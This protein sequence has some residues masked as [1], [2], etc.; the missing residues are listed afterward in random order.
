[1]PEQMNVRSMIERSLREIGADGLVDPMCDDYDCY[2]TGDKMAACGFPDVHR[3]VPAYL[4]RYSDGTERLLPEKPQMD[5]EGSC[6]ECEN[7]PEVD[8]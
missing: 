5:Y 1:M 4:H 8:K 7:S 6:R 2:C 3:C